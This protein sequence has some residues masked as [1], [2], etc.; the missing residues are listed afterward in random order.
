MLIS[1]G[2]RLAY[3]YPRGFTVRVARLPPARFYFLL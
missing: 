1:L 3:R 2:S